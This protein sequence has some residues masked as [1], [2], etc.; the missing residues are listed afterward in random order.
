MQFHQ[1]LFVVV[2]PPDRLDRSRYISGFCSGSTYP[3]GLHR[4]R[5][6][7]DG[8]C[9]GRVISVCINWYVIHAHGILGWHRRGDLRVHRIPVKQRSFFITRSLHALMANRALIRCPA[10]QPIA[11]GHSHD[12]CDQSYTNDSCWFAIHIFPPSRPLRQEMLM[13]VSLCSVLPSN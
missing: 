3:N 13:T 9:R 2:D 5:V 12:A 4:D 6:N 11:S 7:S 8:S 10:R 1:A